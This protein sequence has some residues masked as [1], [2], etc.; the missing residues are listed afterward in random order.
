MAEFTIGGVTEK[1]LMCIY[2]MIM[3]NE[4]L[5]IH[6]QQ[7]PGLCTQ[8]SYPVEN[9][10]QGISLSLFSSTSRIKDMT[11]GPEPSFSRTFYKCLSF[12]LMIP[13]IMMEAKV[14]VIFCYILKWQELENIKSSTI[15]RSV[16]ETL[17]KKF[18]FM[19]ICFCNLHKQILYCDLLHICTYTPNTKVHRNIYYIH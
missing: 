14:F 16:F 12:C 3:C 9:S 11:P 17:S 13:F 5:N 8:L 6:V 19:V 1:H 2:F 7:E 15:H 18:I 4:L 10:E